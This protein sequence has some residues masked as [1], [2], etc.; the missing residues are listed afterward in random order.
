MNQPAV[1]L[2]HSPFTPEEQLRSAQE[3]VEC[4]EQLKKILPALENHSSDTMVCITKHGHYVLG[5]EGDIFGMYDA[6]REQSPQD[7]RGALFRLREARR[8]LFMEQ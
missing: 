7:H 5:S 6:L 2:T 8:W 4:W 3:R 1:H